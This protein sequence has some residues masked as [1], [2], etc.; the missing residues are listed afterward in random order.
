MPTECSAESFDFGTVE[1]RCVEA[2]FDAGL[3]KGNNTFTSSRAAGR[4]DVFLTRR[5]SSPRVRHATGSRKS[6]GKGRHGSRFAGL[7]ARTG[8]TMAKCC[9]G[10]SS[11]NSL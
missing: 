5:R 10:M 7:R 2:A 8:L 9:G 11:Q 3:V 4:P 1:G 6:V